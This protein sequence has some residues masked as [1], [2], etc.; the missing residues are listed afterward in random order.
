MSKIARISGVYI[1]QESRSGGGKFVPFKEF[2]EI[3][4]YLEIFSEI[5][6]NFK[7][8]LEIIA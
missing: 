1:L 8:F 6:M 2:G 4:L 7:D 5:S 3:K